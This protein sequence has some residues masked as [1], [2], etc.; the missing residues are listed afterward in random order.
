MAER[1]YAQ[2]K[3]KRTILKGS[4][5]RLKNFIENAD[6]ASLSR[7]D[8]TSRRAKL[9][10]LLDQFEEL[11]TKIEDHEVAVATADEIPTV[12]EK[13]LSERSEF[14][15]NFYSILSQY[16]IAIHSLTDRERTPVSEERSP[17]NHRVESQ[18]CLPRINLPTFSGS[19]DEWYSFRDTF[20]VLVHKNTDVREVEKII[21]LK[22]CLTGSAL[23]AIHSLQPTAANYK[24][25]WDLLVSRYDN[26]RWIVQG[27]IKAMFELE[28]MQKEDHNTLRDLID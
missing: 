18:V 22:S 14:E 6:M 5:T 23:E 19:Y 2:T 9:A 16:D 3:S 12:E 8:F 28:G 26:I 25:A 27:H 21:H 24:E 17:V 4:V 7:H 10:S 11:Q 20:E 15:N 13:H 1:A